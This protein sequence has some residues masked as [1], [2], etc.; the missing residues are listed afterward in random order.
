MLSKSQVKYIKSLSIKKYRSKYRKFVCEGDKIVKELLQNQSFTLDIL[1]A[2]E[3]WLSTNQHLLNSPTNQLVQITERELKKISNLKSPNEVLAVVDI[4]QF[5]IRDLAGQALCLYLDDIRDPG[6]MGT[7]LRIADWFGL[8]FVFA[9][10]QS[11]D[12]YNPK[13]VQ[14]SMG[15]FLR[16]GHLHCELKE[17]RDLFPKKRIYGTSMEGHNVFQHSLDPGGLIVIGNEGQGISSQTA[18]LVDDWISIP[19]GGGAESLNAAVAT[20]IVCACFKNL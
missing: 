2:T 17:L 6:N 5:Q 12:F 4:P 3:R 9:S 13:V 19:S 14:A 16:V 10:P 18:H 11:V 15:A 20:G 1:F 7:I 8:P